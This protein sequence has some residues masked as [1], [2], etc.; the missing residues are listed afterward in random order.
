MAS[1]EAR[2][3][4]TGAGSYSCGSH[5]PIKQSPKLGS[6][7]VAHLEWEPRSSVCLP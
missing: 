4:A 3:D 1:M 5:H 2:L 6:E 7:E